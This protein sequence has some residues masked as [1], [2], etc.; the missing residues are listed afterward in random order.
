MVYARLPLVNKRAAD[1]YLNYIAAPI[2]RKLC[3]PHQFGIGTPGGCE[4]VIL[5]TQ[6][7]LDSADKQQTAFLC[8]IT[9]AFNTEDRAMILKS[10]YDEPE[11]QTL[12]RSINYTYGAD[13][14]LR[15]PSGLELK[16]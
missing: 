11:L 15:L 13:S 3:E 7:L 8:D 12:W 2:A 14:V 4:K 10:V 6:A 5:A 1:S 16:S 9:N